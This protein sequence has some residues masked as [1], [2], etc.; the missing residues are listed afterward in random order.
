LVT[1]HNH[2]KPLKA[3]VMTRVLQLAAD[4]GAVCRL[5]MQLL[6]LEIKITNH[7]K[8]DTVALQPPLY[9]RNSEALLHCTLALQSSF[10]AP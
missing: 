3:A 7:P 6:P 10:P 4:A 9:S 5:L 8:A 1:N 2:N